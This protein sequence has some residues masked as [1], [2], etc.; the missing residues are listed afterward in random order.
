MYTVNEF[1]IIF[2][3][4][5]FLNMVSLLRFFVNC[6]PWHKYENK[7]KSEEEGDTRKYYTIIKFG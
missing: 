3:H 4:K 6:V 5:L 1:I 7:K 2:I